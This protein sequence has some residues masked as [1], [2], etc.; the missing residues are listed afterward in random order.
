MMPLLLQR[1][2]VAKE[3]S[4][5]FSGSPQI[6]GK[7]QLKLH[8][9]KAQNRPT[10]ISIE[11][12]Q[13]GFV[14]FVAAISIAQPHKSEESRFSLQCDPTDRQ[15]L[16]YFAVRFWL[17]RMPRYDLTVIQSEMRKDER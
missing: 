4:F 15:P 7:R 14:G 9:R 1:D 8:Q 16:C 6:C 5:R 3:Q 11:P 13:A 17:R 12:A 10:P 2:K